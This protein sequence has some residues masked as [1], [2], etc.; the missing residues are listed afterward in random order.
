MKR[1][2]H[3]REL[4]LM[5]FVVFLFGFTGILGKVIT[6]SS[7]WIVFYRMFIA[8]VFMVL[9]VLMFDRQKLPVRRLLQLYGI[10]GITAFHWVCFFESVKLTGVSVALSCLASAAFFTALLEPLFMRRRLQTSDLVQGGLVVIGVALMFRVK[11]ADPRGVGIALLAA[12]SAALFTVLNGRQVQTVGS[13]HITLHEMTGG[14]LWL[15]LYFLLTNKFPAIPVPGS[16]DLLW[17]LVLGIVCTAFGYL[18]SVWVMKKLSPFQVALSV[19]MEPIYAILMAFAF[20]KE[21]QDLSFNFYLGA[22]IILCAVFGKNIF[23]KMRYNK[24]EQ[25]VSS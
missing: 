25:P 24:Q 22:G 3:L 10:G 1:D 7:D 5:H 17:L 14:W 2:S 19:N 21:Y 16:E 6:L 9:Y 12:F 13:A 20:F 23:R 18:V 15:S 8:A 4:L 11:S